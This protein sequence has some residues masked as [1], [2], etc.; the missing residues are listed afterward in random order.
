MREVLSVVIFL[1]LPGLRFLGHLFQA[2]LVNS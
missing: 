1:I 2:I